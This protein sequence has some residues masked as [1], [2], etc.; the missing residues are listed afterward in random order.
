MLHRSRVLALSRG[1]AGGEKALLGRVVGTP[2]EAGREWWVMGSGR[3]W[4]LE[5]QLVHTVELVCSGVG[6]Q[7]Q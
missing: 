1:V 3:V 2:V 6:T 5:A 7:L 4:H